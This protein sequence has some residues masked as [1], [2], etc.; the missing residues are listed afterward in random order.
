[1]DRAVYAKVIADEVGGFVAGYKLKGINV[2]L[3]GYVSAPE[4]MHLM[5]TGEYKIVPEL[6]TKEI[7]IE[8]STQDYKDALEGAETALEFT[9]DEKEKQDLQDYIDGLKIAIETME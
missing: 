2:D 3:S 7:I 9:E 5:E 4:F 6:E 1:M 8:P